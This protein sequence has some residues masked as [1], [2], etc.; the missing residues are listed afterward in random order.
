LD[1]GVVLAGVDN[2]FVFLSND[3][4][5]EFVD[6][7]LD[8]ARCFPLVDVLILTLT[9]LSFSFFESLAHV[10]E[11]LFKLALFALFIVVSGLV[12]QIFS[13]T[14]DSASTSFVHRSSL[15]FL[16]DDSRRGGIGGDGEPIKLDDDLAVLLKVENTG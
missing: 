10:F 3:D 11:T 2:D 5:D 15:E 7:V 4:S 9:D 6:E 12:L 16:R 14:L 1:T 13:S 8:L